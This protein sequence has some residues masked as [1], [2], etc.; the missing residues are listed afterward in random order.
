MATTLW[1]RLLGVTVGLATWSTLTWTGRRNTA[2]E[3]PTGTVS[4]EMTKASS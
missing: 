1:M 4:M 3:T 2:P